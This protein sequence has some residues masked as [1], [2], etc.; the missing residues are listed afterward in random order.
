MS[1]VA[2]ILGDGE[3]RQPRPPARTRRLVHLAKDQRGAREHTGLA[4]FEQQLVPLARALADTGKHR[5]AGV[6]LDRGADQFHDQH[7]LADPG[8]AEHC[9]L[10]AGD[11]RR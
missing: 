5:N 6:A 3:C 1:L 9:C 8:A 11:Q 2:E 4:E 10:P 7:G